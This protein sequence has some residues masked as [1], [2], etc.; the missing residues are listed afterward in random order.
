M[1]P[2]LLNHETWFHQL[3]LLPIP[4]YGEPGERRHVL[5]NGTAGN[6]SLDQIDAPPLQRSS[7]AWSANVGHHLF[8]TAQ[9]IEVVRWD[10]PAAI[11]KYTVSSVAQNIA[12]F[13]KYLE[14]DA[15]DY[16]HSVIAHTLG[17]FRSL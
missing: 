1:A 16:L 5:L 11:E 14:G 3:G 13:H 4:L 17:V 10:R 12:R 6:F 7:I 2:L 15:P 8:V 9:Y